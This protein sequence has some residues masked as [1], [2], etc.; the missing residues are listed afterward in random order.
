VRVGPSRGGGRRSQHDLVQPLVFLALCPLPL[1][2]YCN[3]MRCKTQ[4]TKPQDEVKKQPWTPAAVQR[5]P[6]LPIC[7]AQTLILP[8]S[9]TD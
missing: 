4:H 5:T 1:C 6:F 7:T 8:P 2:L 3:D 9:L